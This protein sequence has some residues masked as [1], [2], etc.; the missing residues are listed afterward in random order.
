MNDLIRL[1]KRD[2]LLVAECPACQEPFRLA[3]ADLF[4]A[5]GDWPAKALEVL[6]Q[7]RLEIRERRA[8]LK[9][10][11]DRMTS[12]AQRTSEAVNLGKIVEKIAPSFPTFGFEPRDCRALLEPIDYVIFQGLARRGRV[13][14]LMFVDVKSG[15]AGLTKSQ[16]QI[17]DRVQEGRIAFKRLP[18]RKGA[19]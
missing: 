6:E 3:D 13:D 2:R 14:A 1:L 19:R 12:G 9:A 17:R 11:K 18:A 10:R 4:P 5:A 16:K 7:R 15:K 8:E